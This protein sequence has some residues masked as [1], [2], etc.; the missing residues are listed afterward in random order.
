MDILNGGLIG[1]KRG[2]EVNE[3]NQDEAEQ[4]AQVAVQPKDGRGKRQGSIG[5]QEIQDDEFE[6]ES[7]EEEENRLIA[8]PEQVAQG[9]QAEEYDIYRQVFVTLS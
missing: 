5:E 3:E 9:L 2:R 6:V 4:P 7:T 1:V 8:L